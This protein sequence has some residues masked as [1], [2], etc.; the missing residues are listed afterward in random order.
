M[1]PPLR[2]QPLARLIS[3]S[4]YLRWRSIIT[5]IHGAYRGR[6]PRD[7]SRLAD[8]RGYGLPLANED[9]LA[10]TFQSQIWAAAGDS[11]AAQFYSDKAASIKSQ[12]QDNGEWDTDEMESLESSLPR[13][14]FG[15]NTGC[16][17]FIII[18]HKL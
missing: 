14:T 2:Q 3:R 7:D 18:N 6:R 4:I 9:Y 17:W 11:Q 8:S 15:R 12:Q 5:E 10:Y 1:Q 13:S 16:L